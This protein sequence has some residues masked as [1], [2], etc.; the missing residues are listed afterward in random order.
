MPT[1][2]VKEKESTTY[3]KMLKSVRQGELIQ[4]RLGFYTNIDQLSNSM[5]D[6]EAIIPSDILSLG[7]HETYTSLRPL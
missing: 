4:V 2:D 3:Y 6:I 7:L 1:A 5:I